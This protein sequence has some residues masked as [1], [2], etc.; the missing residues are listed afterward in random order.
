MNLENGWKR[1]CSLNLLSLSPSLMESLPLSIH[2]SLQNRWQ[3]EKLHSVFLPFDGITSL[4]PSISLILITSPAEDFLLDHFRSTYRN[5]HD[6]TKIAGWES[7]LS[8][9][10]SLPPSIH[11][12]ILINSP[13]EACPCD[14]FRNLRNLRNLQQLNWFA[15]G[16]KT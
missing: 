14:W 4:P 7:A 13:T 3:D 11:P 2:P 8:L 12:P 5:L 6:S 10:L 1:C 9:C 15:N 16:P